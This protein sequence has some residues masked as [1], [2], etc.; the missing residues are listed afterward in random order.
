MRGR[1][2]DVLTYMPANKTSARKASSSLGREAGMPVYC[3]ALA[4]LD[5]RYVRGIHRL[6]QL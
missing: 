4:Y 3:E 2:A 5:D 1:K 6:T